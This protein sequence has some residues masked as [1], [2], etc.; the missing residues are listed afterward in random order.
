MYHNHNLEGVHAKILNLLGKIDVIYST[1]E[2]NYEACLDKIEKIILYCFS[3]G[4]IA[5]LSFEKSIFE[6]DKLRVVM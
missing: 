2:G 6:K 3:V 4:D 5:Y 1:R